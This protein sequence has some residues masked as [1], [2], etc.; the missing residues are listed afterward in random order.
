MFDQKP[1]ARS[2]HSRI[3]TVLA[4]M[5]P[6]RPRP[7]R[8]A[9][10]NVAPCSG[11]VDVVKEAAAHDAAYGGGSEEDAGPATR[12]PLRVLVRDPAVV[13]FALLH[14]LALA[15][16][17]LYRGFTRADAALVAVSYG[18]RM[19]GAQRTGSGS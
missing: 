15:I 6:A 10:I 8:A 9:P 18:T 12:L 3:S 5:C 13:V 11:D 1:P 17:F 14:V 7:R 4:A 19:F 16:P 2:L